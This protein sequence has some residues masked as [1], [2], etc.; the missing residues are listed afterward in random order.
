MSQLLDE[1]GE[2][3]ERAQIIS[4]VGRVIA[5]GC[6]DEELDQEARDCA[7][8]ALSKISAH[9]TLCTER[10]TQQRAA[11]VV[12]G[13]SIE[14]LQKSLDRYIAPLPAGAIAVLMGI[15]GWLTARAFPLGH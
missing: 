8:D 4:S 10:W 12:L 2:S 14:G 3:R 1:I 9:E 6:G 15:C 11:L 7:R 13:H 5:G